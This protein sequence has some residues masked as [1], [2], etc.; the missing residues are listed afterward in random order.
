M[1]F[2]YPGETTKD[3]FELS[4]AL[5]Q[6]NCLIQIHCFQVSNFLGA[7]CSLLTSLL[8]LEVVQSII[9]TLSAFSQEG[10]ELYGC[11]SASL[12]LL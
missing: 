1:L 9:D 6:I 7:E 8:T 11:M 5:T 2:I 10:Y 4:V 3:V 12:R